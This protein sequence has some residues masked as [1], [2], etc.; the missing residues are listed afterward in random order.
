MRLNVFI[1][2]CLNQI[3]DAAIQVNKTHGYPCIKKIK[4]IKIECDVGEA[5]GIIYI[6]HHLESTKNKIIITVDEIEI[7]QKQE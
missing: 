5:D 7:M 2:A 1:E 3:L 4:D 6:P